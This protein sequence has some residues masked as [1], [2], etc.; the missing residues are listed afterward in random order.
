[1]DA[2]GFALSRDLLYIS[3]AITGVAV[4]LFLSLL[5]KGIS[6]RSRNQR[7]VIALICLS[8][9]VA[10]LAISFIVSLGGIFREGAV[11]VTAGICLAIFA[12]AA[13]FPRVVAYPLIL[14]GGLAVTWLGIFCLRF[15]VCD[16]APTLKLS[17]IEIENTAGGAYFLKFLPA[18]R[19]A[20]YLYE[21][22]EDG[23]IQ[24]EG[25][26]SHMTF[27]AA[28]IA[29]ERHFPFVGGTNHWAL[30]QISSDAGIEYSDNSLD[31][32]LVKFAY[33]QPQS[34]S[35]QR[36]LGIGITRMSQTVS[37]DGLTP[38]AEITIYID[39][40]DGINHN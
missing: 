22:D 4:E 21:A 2:N 27:N 5:E 10:G 29:I 18:T 8:V 39:S 19:T 14:L 30:T 17:R 16:S 7:I 26:R 38:S 36:A 15:P 6:A 28:L 13:R 32:P 12:L 9:T 11:L 24:I 40:P 23:T 3:G 20:A 31:S 34:G 33:V 37:L 1:M 35:L 25:T